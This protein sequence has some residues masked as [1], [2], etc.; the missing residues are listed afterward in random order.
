MYKY[1]VTI[2][3]GYTSSTRD[4]FSQTGKYSIKDLFDKLLR[5]TDMAFSD[6]TQELK[7][8][9]MR[10]ILIPDDNLGAKKIESIRNKIESV[11]AEV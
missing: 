2:S 7:H 6:C 9:R 11:L 4:F 8:P 1:T 10:V 3:D 5:E